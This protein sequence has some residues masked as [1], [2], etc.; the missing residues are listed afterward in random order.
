MWGCCL[1]QL[2]EQASHVQRLRPRCSDLGFQSG[3]GVLCC[4]LLP[5]SLNRFPV[6]STVLSIKPKAKKI[7]QSWSINNTNRLMIK[8]ECLCMSVWWLFMCPGLKFWPLTLDLGACLTVC[9]SAA[10]MV[11]DGSFY[12]NVPFS[13][14]KTRFSK[15]YFFVFKD[16]PFNSVRVTGCCCFFP[17]K[18]LRGLLGPNPVYSM[19]EGQATPWISHLLIA[20][21]LMMA[22][23]TTQ[24][25]NCKSGATLEF[26][27]LLKDTLTCGV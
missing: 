4:L 17:R 25:A 15:Y 13:I 23:A 18:G 11:K 22:V 16:F 6:K 8:C 20:G 7:H 21:P 14:L 2:V 9:N 24:G 19:G 27:I 5:L 1:V 26:S 10:K 3:P 12:K